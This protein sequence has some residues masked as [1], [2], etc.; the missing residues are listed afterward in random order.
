[1][2]ESKGFGVELLKKMVFESRNGNYLEK[3]WKY[4]GNTIEIRRFALK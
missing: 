1:L 3:L 4:D 2:H